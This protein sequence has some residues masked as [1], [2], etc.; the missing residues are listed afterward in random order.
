[1]G[2]EKRQIH[3][4]KKTSK[5][6]LTQSTIFGIGSFIAGVLTI[7]SNIVNLRRIFSCCTKY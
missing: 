7:I 5:Y 1:M 6:G 4:Y 2:K 3:G